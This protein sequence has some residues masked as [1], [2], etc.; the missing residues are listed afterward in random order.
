MKIQEEEMNIKS[1]IK[2]QKQNEKR[3]DANASCRSELRTYVK[4]VIV[5]VQDGNLEGARAAFIKAESKLDKAA[6]KGLIHK[7]K[8]SRHKSRLSAKVKALSIM[9]EV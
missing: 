8:A 2:R 7:N 5:A 4:H 9:V 1:A 3:R 6:N